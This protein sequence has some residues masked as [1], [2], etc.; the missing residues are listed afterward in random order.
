MTHSDLVDRAAKW[1]RGTMR[2][3][4]VF[5]EMRTAA[6]EEPD[7]IAWR[8]G[9]ESHL[10]EVKASRSDFLRDKKKLWRMGDGAFGL[11]LYRWYMTVPG[12]I[13]PTE[14]PDNWGLL[15]VHGKRVLRVVEARPSTQDATGTRR[16]VCM[17]LSALRRPKYASATPS[18]TQIF[19]D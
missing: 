8:Y 11:G 2:C 16:E 12:V 7:A 10:V 17:L 13:K 5:T 1:L 6:G 3:P 19:I 18:R 14:L 15:E 4:V 9:G